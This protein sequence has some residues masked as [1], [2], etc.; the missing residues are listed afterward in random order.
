MRLIKLFASRCHFGLKLFDADIIGRESLATRGNN[1]FAIWTAA[2]NVLRNELKMDVLMLGALRNTFK[3]SM[4]GNTGCYDVTTAPLGGPR[5]DL[6]A[7][8]NYSLKATH[9]TNNSQV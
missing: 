2:W 7:I 4:N 3:I 9:E 8:G 5:L 1:C 6:N